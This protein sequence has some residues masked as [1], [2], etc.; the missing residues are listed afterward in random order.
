M[1]RHL[2]LTKMEMWTQL[3]V[4]SLF[5]FVTN[6]AESYKLRFNCN[7]KM[8]PLGDIY[9]LCCQGF[10]TNIRIKVALSSSICVFAPLIPTQIP[11][12]VTSVDLTPQQHT[13]WGLI[14]LQ[15]Q[16]VHPDATLSNNL[17]YLSRFAVF[18]WTWLWKCKKRCGVGY[19]D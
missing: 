13:V 12:L 4:L 17:V 14:S 5:E 18:L 6:L 8:I 1:Q 10:A 11:R 3:T 19:A 2:I 7:F 9:E 15:A 16:C